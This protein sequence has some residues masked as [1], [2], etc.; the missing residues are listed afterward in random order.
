VLGV[1]LCCEYLFDQDMPSSKRRLRIA[2][3][4][5]TKKDLKEL[6]VD[7][8][9]FF[10]R[11]YRG[12]KELFGPRV[13]WD[14]GDLMKFE[15]LN[16]QW[17]NA[18]KP[19]V[20]RSVAKAALQLKF[21]LELEVELSTGATET[22]SKQ[23]VWRFDASAIAGEFAADVFRLAQHPLVK[24]RVNREP[25]SG[26]GRFQSLDL[27]DVH[28]LYPAY[29]QDRGSFV[30][31]Y[32]KESDVAMLFP[33]NLG[34]AEDQGLIS[35]QTSSKLLSL[36]HVFAQAYRSA[37]TGFLEDGV[38]CQ[39]L[40]KQAEAYGILLNAI[41]ADA[42]GDRNR[43][44]LL[45]P[46]LEIGAVAVDGGRVT[47]IVAPWHPLRLAAIAAKANQ[48]AS[49]IR[50]LLS[51]DE[52]FFG[53]PPLFFKELEQELLHPYYPEIVLGWRAD[54]P[55]LLSITD[56]Y[57]DYSLHESPVVSNEGS[58]ETNESPS[59]TSE[60]IVD[61]T[62]RYLSL[63]PHEGANFSVVLYNCDSARLPYALVD[64]MNEL[65]EG[66]EDMRCQI[67]LRHRDG[68]KLRELYERL[69]ESS[70]A[71]A[72][73]FVSSE[74]AKDF[75]ARLR[76]G[77]MADQAPVRDMKD[78]PST[79]IVFLEDVI[80][81]HA[82][83]EWYME[84][85]DPVEWVTLIPARWS[86]RRPSAVDDMKSVVYLCC[87]V[88]TKEGWSF[89]TALTSFLKG[90]WDGV[91]TRRLLP[92]RK[93]DFNDPLTAS[94]FKEVHNL[95]NWVVNYDELLD[96]RQLMNQ[97]VKVIRYKQ[98]TTQGRNIIVSSTAPLNLLRSIVLGRIKDLNLEISDSECRQL[99]EKFINDA[100]EVSG[101]IVLR[102]A[103][104][105]R[106]ARELMGVVL[107]RYMIRHEVGV[108][109]RFGWYF[110]DDYAEWLGQREEQI[111]DILALA[112]QQAAD[113]KLELSVTI[114]EAKYIDIA[115]LAPKRK[116]SQKQLR[117][118]VRRISDAIFGDPRRIDRDLWLSRFSDL[119][120]N[121]IQFP[122]NDPID[123]ASWRKAVRDG[124]CGISLRGYSHIFVSTQADSSDCS[125]FAV[126]AEAKN[127]YQEVFSRTK[128]RELV[129]SYWN[130][131]DP[132][133]IR[134][135]ITTEDIWK[136]LDYG[137]PSERVS[138]VQKH[139]PDDEF[140]AP[141]GVSPPGD[142][143]REPRPK[144]PSPIQADRL[145]GSGTGSMPHVSTPAHSNAGWAYPQVRD[146]VSEYH[147]G[148]QDSAA[149]S[150]WLK[151]VENQ[152]K[153]ALQQ[154]QLQSKLLG[155][156]LTPNAALLKFQGS[157]NLTVE[158]VLRRRSEFLTTHKLNVLSVRAEPGVVAIA[159]ARPNR[160]V[161]H[162]PEVWK[163][164]SPD[165]SRG[166]HELLIAVKEENSQ[167]LF[168]SPKSNAPHTLI[169]G[170]TGSG[171]SVLMQNIILSIA[172]TNTP[173]QAR[174]ALIDPKL[175]V[176]YFAFEG[177]PHLDGALID[178]SDAAIVKLTQLVDEMNR[179][180][181]VL[182][183]NK[184]SNIF[185]L[186]NKENATEY[187]PFLWVIHDEFAEWMMTPDYADAVSD[188]VGR[189][190][191]KARAAGISLVFAAQRPD[192][193]VMPMQLRA[194]LGNRLVLRVDGEGT[195]EIALGEKGAERLLGKGHMAARLEGEPEILFCQVPFV[196]QEFLLAIVEALKC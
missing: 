168:L 144:P 136:G 35:P 51:A 171:K 79:D 34:T 30:G 15:A 167:P 17:R 68:M 137:T 50:Y 126:V 43:K 132:I 112:P 24:C 186:N 119:M 21:L 32:K 105:G 129:L 63:Y 86:R 189:L 76:I 114:A 158:Q 162:L 166:N 85:C 173:Q 12:V 42:K 106:N 170:S 193:N 131:S 22:F 108:H 61:L 156:S 88:Q 2:C 94:V 111:A 135:S 69:I 91:E 49:L 37:I 87:P 148:T 196:D 142:G 96:R 104:R 33:A 9:L 77:I 89:T 62:K 93:L 125:D 150:E 95:G 47:A 152:C 57:L 55:E 116:E 143:P 19:Y 92:A 38:A 3:D 172:C 59:A 138:M 109:K 31:T 124:R 27:R 113:G 20:N 141:G 117:D 14:I 65:H 98:C 36:F 67:I 161:L 54:K 155:S 99:T 102:A 100:N 174:I 58:D 7:A 46:L 134:R 84:T 97:N 81:R 191:V 107:S 177:L 165:C 75:M 140:P 78:G 41:C 6:N 175:G 29:G 146:L 25:V 56:H 118:T 8:G 182:K 23:L 128:L 127:S 39:M 122:A 53:D 176:D 179:R 178:D 64:K 181:S 157:A 188:V 153:G 48:V 147:G 71:D 44:S 160:R 11:R 194:N 60:L 74:A 185:D 169:A 5:R 73:S 164:W 123:L 159:I 70:E 28:T 52:V 101:D 130:G 180:Y 145:P 10:A 26:K 40:Q 16:E 195:S 192:A 121:G 90:D 80:A 4:R 163:G 120:L 154:F 13:S 187:L 83:V 115:N 110:L 1:A 18:T 149:D 133:S 66:E 139:K 82:G 190:G 72:D 184:V 151:Q 45:Q 103:K 183:Q